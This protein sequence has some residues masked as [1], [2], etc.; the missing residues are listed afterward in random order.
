MTGALG[1]AQV[2]S[3]RDA[4]GRCVQ[5]QVGQRSSR[6]GQ[7]CRAHLGL[8]CAPGSAARCHLRLLRPPGSAARTWVCHA[9]LTLTRAP[10]SWRAYLGLPCP[11]GSPAPTWVF[12][13]HVSELAG[14]GLSARSRQ[15]CQLSKGC[16]RLRHGRMP[17]KPG[18]P[19]NPSARQ[20]RVPAKPGCPPNPGARQTWVPAKPEGPQ[21]QKGGVP[22]P[23]AKGAS[24]ERLC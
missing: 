16:L 4:R 11:P 1:G 19:S 24:L 23:C 7:G 14:S 2:T 15:S 6:V 5:S 20:T 9:Q 8:H 10:D 21:T 17:A 18:S 13:P 22:S 12:C 3:R